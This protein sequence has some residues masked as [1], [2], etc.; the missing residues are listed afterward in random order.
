VT[1]EGGMAEWKM[2]M[3]EPSLDDLLE[4]DVMRQVLRSAGTDADGMR[5][6]LRETARR[7]A[8]GPSK[9]TGQQRWRQLCL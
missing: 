2:N 8:L 7:L 1:V 4:D 3:V 6:R 5:R 9:P